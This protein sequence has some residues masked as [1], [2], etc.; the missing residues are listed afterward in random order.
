LIKKTTV[1]GRKTHQ[2]MVYAASRRIPLLCIK[3]YST[4]NTIPFHKS[5][6]NASTDKKDRLISKILS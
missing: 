2:T 4:F 5:T 1:S 6:E 3:T